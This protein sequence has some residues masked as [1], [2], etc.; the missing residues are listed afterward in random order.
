MSDIVGM[1][2]TPGGRWLLA[3]RRRRRCVHFGQ[4]RF[5]GSLPGIHKHVH[6]VMAILP[7]STGTGLRVVGADGGA[8]VFGTGVRFYGS[9]P[10]Q[11][12][13]VANV[14]GIALTPGQWRLLH[15]RG[16][17]QRVRLRRCSRSRHADCDE[18]QPP[19]CR[20][21]R[22]VVPPQATSTD[23]HW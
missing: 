3:G 1:V 16:R 15:G 2:A 7:S 21:R 13:R 20:H 8:F 23:G 6:D 12:V 22:H 10:G 9:L 17:W 14:I 4:S 5:Y 18:R 11:G 19:C